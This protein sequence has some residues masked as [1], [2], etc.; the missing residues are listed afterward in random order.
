MKNNY[1]KTVMVTFGWLA[2]ALAVVLAANHAG[3][4]LPSAA[5]G[6]GPVSTPWQSIGGCGA[7]G[8]GSGSAGTRWMGVGV[9]GG[10]VELEVLPQINFSRTFT[11]AIAAPRLTFAP[12][13]N[14][15]VGLSMPIGA[16]TA[17]VRYQ[18]NLEP[19]TMMNGGRGDL[20][21]DFMRSFGLLGQYAVQFG[22]T[23]PTGKYDEQR[24]A[25]QAKNLLPQG[26][27]MGQGTYAA[28]LTFYYTRDIDKGL[29]ILDGNF[30]Y[31]FMVRFDKK[32]Q[33]LESDY[34]AYRAVTENRERFYYRYMIK[35]YGESDRGD[36]YPPSF[37]V[38]GIYAYR[39]VPRL[40]QSFQL[41]FRAPL[42][43]RWIHAAD[44]RIYDPRPDPDNHA[45]D[46]V[47]SYGIEFSRES[48]PLFL[49]L[50]LPIHDKRGIQGKDLYDPSSYGKWSAPDWEGIGNEWIVAMGFKV[51]MF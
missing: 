14:T 24:G 2:G 1:K 28:L 15:D 35:P 29:F 6:L 20:S 16:K 45:W 27:Q 11:Y 13:R 37:S 34:K 46:A 5:K 39:G 26:L 42:G 7:G 33:Y 38:E 32:N 47:L 21:C 23:F 49:G 17:E 4:F 9:S 19:Q 31:P 8:S 44:P 43:V 18:T 12:F 25:D 10:L 36:F 41:Y 30:N 50:G 48:F 51:A 40:V 22:L 3:G